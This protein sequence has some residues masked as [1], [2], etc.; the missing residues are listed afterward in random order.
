M[1]NLEGY[2]FEK[3]MNLELYSSLISH[4]SRTCFFLAYF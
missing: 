3:Y 2:I 1:L 4:F